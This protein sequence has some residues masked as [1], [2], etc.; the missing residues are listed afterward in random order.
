MSGDVFGWERRIRASIVM[1][2]KGEVEDAIVE[3][4]EAGELADGV[5]QKQG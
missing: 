1:Q 5:E 2:I 4:K 3:Q